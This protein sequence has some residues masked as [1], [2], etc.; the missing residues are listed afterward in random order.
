LTLLLR[1]LYRATNTGN[2]CIKGTVNAVIVLLFLLTFPPELKLRMVAI[3]LADALFLVPYWFLVQ[4]YPTLATGLSLG[5]TVLAISA[6]DWVGGYQTG[7]SGILYAL[8]IVGGHLVLI[9]PL[10]TYLISGLIIAI[11]AGT[12]ALEVNGV[13]PIHFPFT[14]SNLWRVV[15]LNVISMFSLTILTGV[16]TRLYRDYRE[17][18]QRNKELFALNAVSAA[19]SQSLHL[20]EI[21]QLA[22]DKVLEMMELEGGGLYLLE[23][24]AGEMV[25]K[26]HRN[27]TEEFVEQVSRMEPGIEGFTDSLPRTG[28]VLEVDDLSQHPVVNRIVGD[29]NGHRPLAIVPLKAKDRMLGTMNLLGQT[30]HSFTSQDAELLNTIGAQI[31]MVIEN[32]QLYEIEQDRRQMA[33]SLR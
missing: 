23:A 2:Y 14:L 19:A 26:V 16:V 9:K 25:L 18:L 13:I 11:Y 6:G 28:Q 5:I 4:R 24:S 21:L 31:G 10:S 7:A 12:I 15:S 27:L 3:A 22:L 8:L 32:A 1:L 29:G 30:G 20:D 33:E 17:L